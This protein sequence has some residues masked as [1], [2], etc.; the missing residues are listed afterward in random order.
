MGEITNKLINEK[1]INTNKDIEKY[2][3]DEYKP[4]RAKDFYIGVSE[5]VEMKIYRKETTQLDRVEK[6]VDR[7]LELLEGQELS[8]SVSVDKMV[9]SL[10]FNLSEG[11]RNLGAGLQRIAS[12]CY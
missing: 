12:R 7:I 6:K 2:L 4:V 3:N 10:R 8:T 5:D 9:E 1:S 11:E